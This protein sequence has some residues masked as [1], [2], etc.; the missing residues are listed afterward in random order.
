M[1]R[2]SSTNGNGARLSVAN[3]TDGNDIRVL[4][5]DGAQSCRKRH[6]GLFVDL[7]LADAGDVVLHRVLQRD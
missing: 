6:A 1:A 3:L 7:A 4:T 2:N 5:Q